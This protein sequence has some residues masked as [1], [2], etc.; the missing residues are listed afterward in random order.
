M[1]DADFAI[2]L[3]TETV[4]VGEEVKGHV[5][6]S[7]DTKAGPD[8]PASVQLLWRTSGECKPEEKIVADQDVLVDESGRAAFRLQVPAAG[9]MTYAG[10]TLS[11]SWCV[12]ISAEQPVE[13]ALTVVAG[14]APPQSP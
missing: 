6:A 2:D 14:V 1:S 9:P 13:K 3:E 11:I 8:A 5:S 10:Q 4:A 7:A 12:R